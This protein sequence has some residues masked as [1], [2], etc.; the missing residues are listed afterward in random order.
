MYVDVQNCGI[1]DDCLSIV[2]FATSR[3]GTDRSAIVLLQIQDIPKIVNDYSGQMI[4]LMSSLFLTLGGSKEANESALAV[5]NVV[6]FELWKGFQ[7]L[8]VENGKNDW[9]SQ[10]S[11]ERLFQNHIRSSSKRRF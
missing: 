7:S 2:W 9:R 10:E 8:L 11:S 3:F 4:T 5:G 1:R 6:Q